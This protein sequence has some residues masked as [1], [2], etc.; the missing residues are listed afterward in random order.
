MD[1][2][3]SFRHVVRGEFEAAVKW[4]KKA[5]ELNPGH[6]AYRRGYLSALFAA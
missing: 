3:L 1:P 4:S 5:T 2:G 6:F